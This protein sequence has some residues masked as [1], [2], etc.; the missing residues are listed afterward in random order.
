VHAL[1][2][3]F[4]TQKESIEQDRVKLSQLLTSVE[5][6]ILIGFLYSVIIRLMILLL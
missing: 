2:I 6:T 3:R 5:V 4:E 1:L